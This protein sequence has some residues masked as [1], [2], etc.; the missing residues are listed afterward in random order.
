[1]NSKE[2]KILDELKHELD[3]K[4]EILTESEND[5]K[6]QVTLKEDNLKEV[7]KQLT[8]AQTLEETLRRDLK[9]VAK[10]IEVLERRDIEIRNEITTESRQFQNTKEINEER[11]KDCKEKLTQY[12]NDTQEKIKERG[13]ES[14][15]AMHNMNK[16]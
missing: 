9:R 16:Y 4:I 5:F 1:M 3:E 13:K 6:H 11:V 15:T 12:I 7:K 14:P 8:E 2:A 10:D